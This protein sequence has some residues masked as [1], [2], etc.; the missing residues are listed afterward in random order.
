MQ[1]AEGQIREDVMA[2]KATRGTYLEVVKE[3][4]DLEVVAREVEDLGE[5]DLQLNSK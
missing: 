4:E 2:I 3:V 1:V 5:G